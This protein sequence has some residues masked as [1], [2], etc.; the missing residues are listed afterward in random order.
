[1]LDTAFDK[2]VKDSLSEA[3]RKDYVRSEN[4]VWSYI[5]RFITG[6]ATVEYSI[7]QLFGELFGCNSASTMLTYSLDL[8]KK[9]EVI[10]I[11]LKSQG[12]DVRKDIKK[13]QELHD[14]RNIIAHWPFCAENDGL[15]VDYV[16]KNGSLDL[17]PRRKTIS[18]PYGGLPFHNNIIAYSKFDE[19][20]REAAELNKLFEELIFL[21]KPITD[22]DSNLRI[23]LEDAILSSDNVIHF[24]KQ[25]LGSKE[26]Q[27]DNKE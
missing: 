4:V 17:P 24:P 5:G 20:D 25:P 27:S 22:A 9:L 15:F 26:D 12:I 11:A 10:T 19:Y 7:N 21:V 8:R 18:N 3:Q 13:V 1:M 23:A 16:H 14:I 6:F 2:E